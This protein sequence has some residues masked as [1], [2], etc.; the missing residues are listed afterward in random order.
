[1][2][3]MKT[4]STLVTSEP[5]CYL[6]LSA[7]CMCTETYFFLFKEISCSMLPK[8]GARDFRNHNL[9]PT[10]SIYPPQKSWGDFLAT[11]FHPPL[12]V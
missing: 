9:S 7:R 8:L 4:K 12:H 11:G 3:D 2:D 10:E 1:M 5:R 6:A